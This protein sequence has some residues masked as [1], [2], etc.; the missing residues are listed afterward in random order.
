MSIIHKI[1]KQNSSLRV[2]LDK[3]FEPV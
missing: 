2:G 1:I 3:F